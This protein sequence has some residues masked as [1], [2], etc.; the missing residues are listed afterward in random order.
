V[1]FQKEQLEK[2]EGGSDLSGLFPVSPQGLLYS[3][4]RGTV[5]Y[6]V[7]QGGPDVG[8]PPGGREECLPDPPTVTI[9][10]TEETE[11]DLTADGLVASSTVFCGEELGRS[12]TVP[13]GEG[14]GDFNIAASSDNIPVSVQLSVIVIYKLELTSVQSLL[15]LNN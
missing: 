6:S 1:S 15:G 10:C 3:L 4:S 8:V 2:K 12:A 11:T 14:F 13:S 9:D 7:V 5:T